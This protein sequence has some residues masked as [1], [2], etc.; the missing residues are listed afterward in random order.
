MTIKTKISRI[1]ETLKAQRYGYNLKYNIG[2]RLV[3][4][5]KSCNVE[6]IRFYKGSDVPFDDPYVEYKGKDK[7]GD[8]LVLQYGNCFSS[9]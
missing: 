9:Q 4:S 8:T 1:V 5:S 2:D 7:N 3:L 6:S